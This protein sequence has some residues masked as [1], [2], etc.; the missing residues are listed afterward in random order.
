MTTLGDTWKN[1]EELPLDMSQVDESEEGGLSGYLPATSPSTAPAT[2][3]SNG[4]VCELFGTSDFVDVD[5]IPGKAFGSV[6]YQAAEAALRS[7]CAAKSNSSRGSSISASDPE[8]TAL[9]ALRPQGE[10]RLTSDFI[11]W[12]DS[13]QALPAPLPHLAYKC[14]CCTQLGTCTAELRA[15]LV[16]VERSRRVEIDALQVEL[17]AERNARDEAVAEERVSEQEREAWRERLRGAENATRAA[18]ITAGNAEGEMLRMHDEVL[19]Q[20]VVKGKAEAEIIRLR[21]DLLKAEAE[22]TA[23]GRQAIELGKARKGKEKQHELAEEHRAELLGRLAKLGQELIHEKRRRQEAEDKRREQST[24]QQEVEEQLIFRIKEAEKGR[25]EAL[26]KL[27]GAQH[28]ARKAGVLLAKQGEALTE[29]GRLR[30]LLEEERALRMEYERRNIELLEDMEKQKQKAEDG[31]H[32]YDIQQQIPI[33]QAQISCDLDG[34][35]EES[36]KPATV[37]RA[38]IEPLRQLHIEPRR[39]SG[40]ER[41]ARSPQKTTSGPKTPNSNPFPEIPSPA[42]NQVPRS[43]GISDPSESIGQAQLS[44]STS[45]R[46]MDAIERMRERENERRRLQDDMKA[47]QAQ[48]MALKELLAQ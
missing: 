38:L 36:S 5:V 47:C 33:S 7:V 10:H 4:G 30:V 40:S 45:S 48:A 11:H 44:A 27:K 28:E 37:H 3:R 43:M 31:E 46:L 23:K 39:S 21:Q 15:E 25:D 1:L 18:E 17:Q 6:R 34:L 13:D 22:V 29:E 2:H 26:K 19:Q 20:E 9:T 14:P 12:L 35:P 41:P 32:H 42:R 16:A 8:D 24:K